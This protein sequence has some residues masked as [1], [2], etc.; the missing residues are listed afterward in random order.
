MVR[1]LGFV[2]ALRRLLASVTGRQAGGCCGF[3]GQRAMGCLRR[4]ASM[5]FTVDSSMGLVVIR[6]RT[7]PARR[8]GVGGGAT[9]VHGGEVIPVASSS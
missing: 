8:L 9:R 5:G 1:G 2:L 4:S 7:W 3:G 6:S